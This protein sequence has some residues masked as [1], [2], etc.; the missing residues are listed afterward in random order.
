M[1]QR[2]NSDLGDDR[3]AHGGSESVTPSA[4]N[5]TRVELVT[6]TDQWLLTSVAIAEE[7]GKKRERSVWSEMGSMLKL[8]RF[9][10]SQFA[11]FSGVVRGGLDGLTGLKLVCT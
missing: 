7:D 11:F 4:N 10:R 1:K 9:S 6:H 8:S 2:R 5:T 3:Y